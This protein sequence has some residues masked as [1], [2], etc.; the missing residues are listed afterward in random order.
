VSQWTEEE[1]KKSTADFSNLPSNDLDLLKQFYP[2]L[3]FRDLESTFAADEVSPS[4]PFKNM[5]EL[6]L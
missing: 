5:K 2:T 3:N 1:A 4:F 6:L